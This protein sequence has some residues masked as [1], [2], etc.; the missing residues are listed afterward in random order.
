M[1]GSESW[2]S[3]GAGRCPGVYL[4]SEE[5]AGQLVR[6]AGRAG[7]SRREEDPRPSVGDACTQTVSDGFPH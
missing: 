4:L 7:R 2:G 3:N 5:T 6:R 1:P